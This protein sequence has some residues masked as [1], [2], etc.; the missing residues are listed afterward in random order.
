MKAP[1][2]SRLLREFADLQLRFLEAY[3]SLLENAGWDETKLNQI[4]KALTLSLLPI[5][6]AQGSM[7]EQ[8]LAL[9]K[10]MVGQYRRFLEEA[11]RE[12]REPR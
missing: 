5:V 1:A 6:R 12:Q 10:A 9:H 8:L 4:L 2:D 7:A 3:E 11:L